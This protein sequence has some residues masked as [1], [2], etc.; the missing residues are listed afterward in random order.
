[1][2]INVYYKTV[3][4]SLM[5][6]TERCKGKAT[7]TSLFSCLYLKNLAAPSPDML[8]NAAQVIREKYPNPNN[9]TDEL[10]SEIKSFATKF[11]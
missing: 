9:F 6:L 1:M 10:D 3:D 4:A 7:V 8:G 2:K 11:R 5:Q